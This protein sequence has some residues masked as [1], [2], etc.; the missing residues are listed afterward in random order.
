MAEHKKYRESLISIIIPVYNTERYLEQCLVSVIN[1]T[2]QNIQIVVVNDGSKDESCSICARF[3]EK[4]SRIQLISKN[5]EG[6]STARNVGLMY[7]KGDYVC[8]IDSDD[9]VDENFVRDLYELIIQKDDCNLAI[10][11]YTEFSDKAIIGQTTGECEIFDQKKAFEKL[12]RT[13]SFRGYVCNKIFVREIIKKHHL[14]FSTTISVWEDVL[15][16]SEYLRYCNCVI[17]NPCSYYYY[18]YHE[19]SASHNQGNVKKAMDV[20]QAQ[21]T[22][23]HQISNEL[24]SVKE[25]IAKRILLSSIDAFR[26][27]QFSNRYS[28]DM[29]KE[30][31]C[32]INRY[33]KVGKKN[34]ALIDR[35][36]VFLCYRLHSFYFIILRFNK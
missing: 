28:A 32:I 1:Q 25:I 20:L 31:K 22:I 11:G 3:A 18:R 27:F 29:I 34:L 26:T 21:I 12:Y 7:A 35:I 13:D 24:I 8:F 14:E 2:Y 4:D 23:D 5:N 36:K 33:K 15:F 6:V 17:Y 10:C 19:L 16:V 9:Y 30:V